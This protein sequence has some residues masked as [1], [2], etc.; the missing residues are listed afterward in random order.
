MDRRY[1]QQSLD[2]RPMQTH[3]AAPFELLLRVSNTER[4][5]PHA[6]EASRRDL[7]GEALLRISADHARPAKRRARHQSKEDPRD[8]AEAGTDWEPTRSQHLEGAPGTPQ[9]P[10]S[11]AGPRDL[12]T[13]TSVEY[14]HHVH[15]IAERLRVPRS[16]DGLY[17][18]PICLDSFSRRIC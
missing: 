13:A 16:G 12:R 18:G 9:V 1:T 3:R 4:L 7:H 5:R 11:S 6:H 8:H 2:R 15:P 14:R 10:V 17:S